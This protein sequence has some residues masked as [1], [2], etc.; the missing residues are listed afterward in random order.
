VTKKGRER[1]KRKKG[2]GEGRTRNHLSKRLILF[3]IG[4][5]GRQGRKEKGGEEKGK[6]KEEIRRTKEPE[7]KT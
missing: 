2:K 5:S 1:G 3:L 6:E 4:G 7:P